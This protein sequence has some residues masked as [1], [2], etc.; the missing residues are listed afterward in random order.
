LD[1]HSRAVVAARWGYAE[2]AVAL[3]ETLK[4]GLAARGR[5]AQCYVD[6]ADLRIM[7]TSPRDVRLVNGSRPA[8][9]A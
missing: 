7:P 3:R 6:Y 4:I 9:S 1:D 5:P 2:N 8:R